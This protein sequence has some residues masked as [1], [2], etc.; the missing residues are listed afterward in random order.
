MKN[1]LLKNNLERAMFSFLL[2]RNNEKKFHQNNNLRSL[3]RQSN[4]VEIVTKR[5][6]WEK[7]SFVFFVEITSTCKHKYQLLVLKSSNSMKKR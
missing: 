2:K 5:N 3:R 4:K 6:C 1:E 7:V